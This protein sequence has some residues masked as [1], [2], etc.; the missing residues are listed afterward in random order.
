MS[1]AKI[2]R[3]KNP[4]FGDNFPPPFREDR[5]TKRARFRDEEVAGEH[6]MRVSYKET[7]VNSSQARENEYGGGATDWD[8]EEGDVI[9]SNDGPMPS[10]AFSARIH[11]KLSEPW[12]N[13]RDKTIWL[14]ATK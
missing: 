10:I 1:S 7:L 13:L 9:E 11:E 5:T 6:H 12:K 2:G 4:I 3:G 14:S 8:F